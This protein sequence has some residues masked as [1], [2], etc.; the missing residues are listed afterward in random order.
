MG[1]ALWAEAVG[2]RL[3]VRLID[4]LEHQLQRALDNAVP[5]NGNPEPAALARSRLWQVTV[6][7]LAH[8]IKAAEKEP[9]ARIAASH[10][11]HAARSA[12]CRHPLCV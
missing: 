8:A 4:R 3:E 1:S 2:T 11:I 7:S 5:D 6:G 12:T 10:S 9:S